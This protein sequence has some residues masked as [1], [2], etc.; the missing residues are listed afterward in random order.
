MKPMDIIQYS[1]GR[2]WVAFHNHDDRKP[3]IFRLDIFPV[4]AIANA[5]PLK[6]NADRYARM[7]L[8]REQLVVVAMDKGDKEMASC[9]RGAHHYQFCLKNVKTKTWWKR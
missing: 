9:L 6:S 7:Q 4:T 2:Y 5:Y 3:Q 1:Q 8:T